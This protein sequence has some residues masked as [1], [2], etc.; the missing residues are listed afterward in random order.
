MIV[1]N[2]IPFQILTRSIGTGVL[3]RTTPRSFLILSATLGIQVDCLR[4]VYLST[5]SVVR[6]GAHEHSCKLCQARLGSYKRG[7]HGLRITRAN[8]EGKELQIRQMGP[9]LRPRMS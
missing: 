4:H 1:D 5:V 2:D 6:L 9:D 8:D 3:W 7:N